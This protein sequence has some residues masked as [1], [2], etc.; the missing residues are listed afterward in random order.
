MTEQQVKDIQNIVKDLIEKIDDIT[1][2]LAFYYGN[3]V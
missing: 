2:N 3:E 1:Q